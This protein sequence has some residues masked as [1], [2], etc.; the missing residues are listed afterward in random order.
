MRLSLGIGPSLSRHDLPPFWEID[1]TRATP[2][3]STTAPSGLLYSRASSAGTTVQTGTSSLV[4]C[5]TTADVLRFGRALDA[6]DVGLVHETDTTTRITESNNFSS[7]QITTSG[8]VSRTAAPDV[9][10]PLGGSAATRLTTPD[11]TGSLTFLKTGLALNAAQT[12]SIWLRPVT[13]GTDLGFNTTGV[14][15]STSYAGVILAA[16]AVWRRLD[17]TN[18]ASAGGGVRAYPLYGPAMAGLGAGPRDWYA[19]GFGFEP[20]LYPHE[21]VQTSGAE[22]TSAGDLLRVPDAQWAPFASDGRLRLELQFRPKGARVELEGT[23]YLFHTF[24]NA[25]AWLNPATGLLTL[26]DTAGATN[27]CTLPS[28]ARYALTDL[29]IA[30]GGGA[31]TVVRY[32]LDSGITVALSVTG[33]ALG[34]MRTSSRD[35]YLLNANVANQ[36]SC[37]LYRARV[38]RPGLTPAWVA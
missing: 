28:F 27:T 25:S 17:A 24:D 26:R 34:S 32:R 35:L 8:T 18:F 38:W 36:L 20:G 2:G 29:W 30:V 37:W 5:P 23:P 1:F 11:G 15:G 33:S 4:A 10:D 7:A 21:T 6:W 12:A 3:Y 31:T 9:P 14:T 13:P 22:R 16:P 19:W